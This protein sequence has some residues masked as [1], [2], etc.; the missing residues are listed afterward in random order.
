MREA[1]VSQKIIP[2]LPEHIPLHIY[3]LDE[4]T[5]AVSRISQAAARYGKA[6]LGLAVKRTRKGNIDSLAL[7]TCREVVIITLKGSSASNDQLLNLLA[8]PTSDQTGQLTL[9]AFGMA[10]IAIQLSGW[11]SDSPVVGI[12]LSTSVEGGA[13]NP[14]RPSEKLLSRVSSDVEISEVHDLWGTSF[15]TEASDEKLCLRAWITAWCAVF[16]PL[17]D[18]GHNLTGYS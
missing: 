1:T 18:D 5:K 15:D 17:Y 6:Y 13:R 12:D 9:V 7:G 2:I 3:S 10:R 4:A 16:L 14:S 11:A 8:G